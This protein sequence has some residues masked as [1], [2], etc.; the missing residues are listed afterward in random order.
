MPYFNLDLFQPESCSVTQ[1]RQNV[2]PDFS[3][4][5]CAAEPICLHR[6]PV[7][8]QSAVGIA[9]QGCDVLERPAEQQ[10]DLF[11]I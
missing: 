1:N 11:T 8:S 5:F 7:S 4:F 6:G 3:G 10:P 9:A 2:S